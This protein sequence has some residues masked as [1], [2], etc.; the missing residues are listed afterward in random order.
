MVEGDVGG[1]P[2]LVQVVD[3]AVV[4]VEAARVGR[5]AAAGLDARPGDR[6]A[7]GRHPERGHQRDVV[8]VAVVVVAGD[9]AG[10]ALEDL[11]G[12][13]AE[14]VPDARPAS[15]VAD[16]PLD[17][18]GGGRACPRR[19]LAGIPGPAP[20]GQIRRHGHAAAPHPI[21]PPT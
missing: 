2:G 4:E 21:R 8:A 10:V 16:G 7:V 17:L 13:G 20:P 18:V 11:A 14:R 3:E 19:T 9:L 15:P 12:G 5:A 6:E 1:D